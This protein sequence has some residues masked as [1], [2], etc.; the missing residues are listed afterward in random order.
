MLF[1]QSKLAR[2]TEAGFGQPPRGMGHPLAQ[3]RVFQQLDHAGRG[4]GRVAFGDKKTGFTVDD[5][6]RYARMR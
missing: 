2:S 4:G 6:L 1:Q 5:R 3:I